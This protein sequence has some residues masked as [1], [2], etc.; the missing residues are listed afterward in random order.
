MFKKNLSSIRRHYFLICKRFFLSPILFVTALILQGCVPDSSYPITPEWLNVIN[1]TDT[2]IYIRYGFLK[3]IAGIGINDSTDTLY[4]GQESCFYFDRS[5][6]S[7]LWMSESEFDSL[8]SKISIYK[9][10]DGDTTYVERQYFDKKGVWTHEVYGFDSYEEI[11][12][13]NK[14]I[15]TSSM[16]QK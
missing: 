7:K 11:G 5:Y 16:F 8:V 9:V 4:H 15:V 12:S 13:W 2:T 1:E 10:T 3:S 6:I 14:L